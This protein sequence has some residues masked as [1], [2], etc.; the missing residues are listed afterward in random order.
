MSESWRLVWRDGFAPSFSDDALEFLKR[1]LLAD[2][3]KLIQGGTTKPPPLMCVRDWPCEAADAIGLCGVASMGGFDSDVTVGRVEE[4]FA[5]VCFDADQR[6]G[7]PAACR[8]FLNWFDDTPRDEMRRELLEEV[9]KV[10]QQ[11]VTAMKFP[12]GAV[13]VKVPRSEFPAIFGRKSD[14]DEEE[15]P[16]R[17]VDTF[18]LVVVP[19]G[20]VACPC[21]DKFER[22]DYSFVYSGA[23]GRMY[24]W[25]GYFKG[26]YYEP[27]LDVRGPLCLVGCVP[28][29]DHNN[30][31]ESVN[32][33][34]STA[35]VAWLAL[36]AVIGILLFN[37]LVRDLE[38]LLTLE[39]AP[40][41]TY[42]DRFDENEAL[43]DY[44]IE[45][46]SELRRKLELFFGLK[47]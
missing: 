32:V 23:S 31:P 36:R 1:A 37:V 28:S 34:A 18:N 12:A 9:E 35:G 11:R 22:L 10:L 7:E 38:T 17:R 46:R 33:Y 19:S 29:K 39:D 40:F 21:K 20:L 14:Y 27:H 44:T 16:Y 41:A 3:P 13:V 26:D 30:P 8:W 5:R 47:S 24:S 4:F 43:N 42:L 15:K 2:D 45:Y 6:L 25:T